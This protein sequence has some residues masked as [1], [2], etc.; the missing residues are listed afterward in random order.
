MPA[1]QADSGLPYPTGTQINQSKSRHTIGTQIKRG[2]S[3]HTTGTKLPE[4]IVITT[5]IQFGI[6]IKLA[7]AC[8]IN[9]IYPTYRTRPWQIPAIPTGTHPYFRKQKQTTGLPIYSQ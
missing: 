1:L 2:K 9:R 7:S 3:R 4:E 8:Q 5:G 6:G